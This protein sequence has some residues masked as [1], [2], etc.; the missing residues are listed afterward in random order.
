MANKIILGPGGVDSSIT[1]HVIVGKNFTGNLTTFNGKVFVFDVDNIPD[2]LNPLNLPRNTIRVKFTEGYT[3]TMGDTQTR[4]EGYEDNVWDI[5][6]SSNDW[7][8]MFQENTNL[9]E[10]LG[11]NTSNI[12]VM[13][14]MFNKCSSLTRV[15]PFDTSGCV[16]MY[17]MFSQCT[18]LTAVPK[19]SIKMCN[20]TTCMYQACYN[21]ESGILEAYRYMIKTNPNIPTHGGTFG[22]CGRDTVTGAAELA[23]I[24]EDWK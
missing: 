22:Y 19:L 21:V 15:V 8:Y 13:T 18:S 1:N 5:F 17:F 11:A 4:V 6:K 12:Y 10:V 9:L 14:C 7:D 23:L 3:P 2:P 20:I 24:P 16:G